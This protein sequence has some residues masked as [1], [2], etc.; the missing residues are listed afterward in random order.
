[1][2]NNMGIGI[3]FMAVDHF[4]NIVHKMQGSFTSLGQ[5]MSKFQDKHADI[6]GR[7]EGGSFLPRVKSLGDMMGFVSKAAQSPIASFNAITEAMGPMKVAAA[8]AGAGL[9][10]LAGAFYLAG[11]AKEFDL[12][13]RE[14]GA[15]GGYTAEQMDTLEG[16][17]HSLERLQA[18]RS[19]TDQGVKFTDAIA[20]VNDVVNL[21][22][23]SFGRL[24]MEQSA[25][26]IGEALNVFPELE[27]STKKA[28]DVMAKAIEGLHIKAEDL[29]AV[30][31]AASFAAQTFGSSLSETLPFIALVKDKVGGAAEAGQQFHMMLM[32]LESAG[33]RGGTLAGMAEIMDAT[34]ES[35]RPLPA[36]MEDM[37]RNANM[38][39]KSELQN[40]LVEA[41][42]PRGLRFAKAQIE[43]I[44][45]KAKEFGGDYHKAVQSIMGDMTKSTA[46]AEDLAAKNGE[47]WDAA[48]SQISESMEGAWTTV[49]KAFLDVLLPVM[50]TARDVV[51][52]LADTFNEIPMAIKRI[53]A[54]SVVLTGLGLIFYAMGGPISLVVTA[55]GAVVATVVTLYKKLEGFRILVNAFWGGIKKAFSEMYQTLKSAFGEVQSA[56]ME[57]W[58]AIMS[59]LEP[60]AEAL[61]L[62][63]PSAEAKTNLQM[64]GEFIADYVI[65]PIRIAT[66]VIA[67]M[68]RVFAWV[69]RQVA[70]LAELLSG[71]F[72]VVAGLVTGNMDLVFK[73][74]AKG[75]NAVVGWINTLIHDAQNALYALHF[76][77]K[78]MALEGMKLKGV[79]AGDVAYALGADE[80]KAQELKQEE[81]TKKLNKAKGAGA[82]P[83]TGATPEPGVVTK[84]DTDLAMQRDRSGG[85]TRDEFYDGI[86]ELGESIS[87]GRPIVISGEFSMDG[88]K[89]ATVQAAKANDDKMRT[90][91]PAP[92]KP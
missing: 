1:M 2:L 67:G 47:A 15:T 25:K 66:E 30:M 42:G 74:I 68:A 63:N 55:I 56:F 21:T 91:Q 81:A 80:K 86:R 34:G 90:G 62:S 85:I 61:G 64:V 26:L 8:A 89:F 5:T 6:F 51:V 39:T 27:N 20:G 82:V 69:V 9:S 72:E 79:D 23:G 57:V 24:N 46:T 48:S 13:L 75:V 28:S 49:K 18:F 71:A 11:E 32:R 83:D 35:M 45:K 40:S 54:A 38:M 33:K 92:R 36:I 44:Q 70:P 50:T 37:A 73:G 29:P 60:L 52:F 65:A 31:N 88:Q 77:D 84:M 16:S 58:T 59:A 12:R 19:L 4:T 87:Q 7:G 53:G 43:E 22:R 78:A 14:I 3:T 10:I 17:I 76:D 41:F